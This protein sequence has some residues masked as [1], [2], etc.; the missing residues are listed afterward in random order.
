MPSLILWVII[1]PLLI[2]FGMR[3]FKNSN[4]LKSAS[5]TLLF[6]FAYLGYKSSG[7]LWEFS[8]IFLSIGILINFELITE[9]LLFREICSGTLFVIYCI[10]F[11][12]K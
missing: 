11:Y 2:V 7:Y 12:Q 9:E 6:G 1:Y 3:K 5:G 10:I 4:R 8:K